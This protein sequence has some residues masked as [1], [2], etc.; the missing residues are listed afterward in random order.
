[1]MVVQYFPFP[2]SLE[3]GLCKY[4]RVPGSLKCFAFHKLNFPAHQD[5]CFSMF[6][7]LPPETFT[8]ARNIKYIY[9]RLPLAATIK[10][11]ENR[12]NLN[13]WT[14]SS[15]CVWWLRYDQKSMHP[16]HAERAHLC[17]VS[18][19]TIHLPSHEYKRRFSNPTNSAI[20]GAKFRTSY[21]FWIVETLDSWKLKGVSLH[22]WSFRQHF[23]F[24]ICW[25]DF[26]WKGRS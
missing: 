7:G 18:A 9:Y 16:L 17:G 5:A 6:P 11:T 15:N 12:P 21:L 23:E 3:W 14:T 20:S 13:S 25:P 22:L 8:T 2:K 26:S 10:I 1:M 19:H 4:F 24:R